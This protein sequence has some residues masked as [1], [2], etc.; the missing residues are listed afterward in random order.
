MLQE[1]DRKR[2]LKD[3]HN[4]GEARWNERKEEL[5]KYLL[6][7]NLSKDAI[8]QI[9]ADYIEAYGGGINYHITP[10]NLVKFLERLDFL[11][12]RDIDNI[13]LLGVVVMDYSAML[14][15]LAEW[16]KGNPTDRKRTKEEVEE[17]LYENNSN[18]YSLWVVS[19]LWDKEYKTPYSEASLQLH[20]RR[21][22]KVYLFASFVARYALNATKEEVEAILHPLEDGL[23][24]IWVGTE[25][26]YNDLRAT[27]KRA[28]AERAERE[29]REQQATAPVVIELSRPIAKVM[30]ER[31]QSLQKLTDKQRQGIIITPLKGQPAIPVEVISQQLLN[32][33]RIHLPCSEQMVH[34]ALNGL[35]MLQHFYNATPQNGIYSY[36]LRMTEFAELCY[37]REPSGDE[38]RQMVT[39]LSVL[40]ERYWLI[41]GGKKAVKICSVMEINSTERGVELTIS[42]PQ[43]ILEYNPILA[44][45]QNILALRN[46]QRGLTQ[47]RFNSQILCKGHKKEADLLDACFAYSAR[48]KEVE[49]YPAYNKVKRDIQLHRSQDKKRLNGWFDQYQK[50]GILTYT[51]TENRKGEMV[52]S[53][54]LLNPPQASL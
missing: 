40:Q 5:N 21:I 41:D 16:D 17:W 3:L 53:W 25:H 24:E 31:V 27:E 12:L 51:K 37:G 22:A 19:K 46:S 8:E 48:L 47:A 20:S 30:S 43:S 54:Q 23:E 33:G 4:R 6:S 32:D 29:R 50:N 49:G 45:E 18:P 9:L 10:E 38:S 42:I 26:C 7:L 28:E 13:V 44:Q 36:R 35:N 52:Y 14:K 2:I 1:Q 15:A 11:S 34:N 39:A